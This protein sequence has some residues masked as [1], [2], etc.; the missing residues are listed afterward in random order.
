M[1]I[2]NDNHA[3]H[4]PMWEIT[5]ILQPQFAS[6]GDGVRLIVN[7]VATRYF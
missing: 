3:D 7:L 6:N 1:E 2:T 5:E 4:V